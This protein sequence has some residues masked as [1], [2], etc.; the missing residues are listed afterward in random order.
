[1]FDNLTEAMDKFIKV[2]EVIEPDP[3]WTKVYDKMYPYYVDMYRHLD[4]D[5]AKM[6]K[7]LSL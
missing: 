3:E 7:E 6:E 2:K 5:L 1:M 4:S